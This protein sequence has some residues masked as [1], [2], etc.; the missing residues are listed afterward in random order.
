MLSKSTQARNK[1]KDKSLDLCVW[2]LNTSLDSNSKAR[3]IH[4]QE[5]LRIPDLYATSAVYHWAQSAS[6]NSSAQAPV[7]ADREQR[8]S[9]SLLRRREQERTEKC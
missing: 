7:L 5:W 4:Q 3:S 1:H 8:S 9:S 6:V 2:I